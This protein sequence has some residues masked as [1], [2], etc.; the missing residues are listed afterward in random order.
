MKAMLAIG[1]L[2]ALTPFGFAGELNATK[3]VPSD[4]NENQRK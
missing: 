2:V 3:P 1:F 4:Q